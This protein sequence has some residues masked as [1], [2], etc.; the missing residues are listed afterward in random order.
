MLCGDGA[1]RLPRPIICD[2]C[3]QRASLPLEREPQ[4]VHRR[5]RETGAI[6][7]PRS[8]IQFRVAESPLMDE[9]ARR[10]RASALATVAKRDLA[11]YY[12]LLSQERVTLGAPEAK[13]VVQ[14]LRYVV[15]QA[16][17]WPP[18]KSITLHHQM[19]DYVAASTK[20]AVW[21]ETLGADLIARMEALT[22]AQRWAV[23]DAVERYWLLERRGPAGLREVGLVRADDREKNDPEE[24]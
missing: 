16:E 3:W 17:H 5:L 22:P 20:S 14:A 10:T 2:A 15:W 11:R 7:R 1:I 12:Q 23:A 6:V 9:L 19:R 13:H 18:G 21:R 4:S 8:L 24:A